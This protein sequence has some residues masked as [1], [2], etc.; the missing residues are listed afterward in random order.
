MSDNIIH[1]SDWSKSIILEI[2]AP[3][4]GKIS[5]TDTEVIEGALFLM[6]LMPSSFYTEVENRL[7]NIAKEGSSVLSMEDEAKVL[8]S[9]KCMYGL[10]ESGR[11]SQ[12]ENVMGDVLDEPL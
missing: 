11:R 8:Q 5:M 6:C 1:I 2:M 9:F 12:Y 3:L 4:Q 7:L 10:Q